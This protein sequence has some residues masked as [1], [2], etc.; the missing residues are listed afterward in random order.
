METIEAIEIL[1]ISLRC[2]IKENFEN[3]G[4]ILPVIFFLVNNH[5]VITPIP[6]EFLNDERK[7]DLT[8][9]IKEM[10]TNSRISCAGIII[11]AWMHIGNIDSEMSK[12]LMSGNLQVRDIK[13]KEDI[14]VLLFSTPEKEECIIFHVNPKEKKV[15]KE[16]SA[17]ENA[18]GVFSNFFELRNKNKT[19]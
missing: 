19:K 18:G 3:D 16:D 17:I 12:L 1:K 9:I 14:V 2:G 13:E 10:C 15:I 7:P 4:K 8:Y 11:E 5:P 6:E